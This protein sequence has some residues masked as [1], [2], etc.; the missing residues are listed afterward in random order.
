MIIHFKAHSMTERNINEFKKNRLYNFKWKISI[1]CCWFQDCWFYLQF[2]WQISWNNKND[3]N[4][5]IIFLSKCF[6]NSCIYWSLCVLQNLNHEFCYYYRFYLSSSKEREIFYVKRKIK[7][8]N[9]YFKVDINDC[10]CFKIFKL[11]LFNW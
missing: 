9:E 2:K 5:K 3:K 1:L 6:W 8:C 7:D 10:I 11:F 4:I